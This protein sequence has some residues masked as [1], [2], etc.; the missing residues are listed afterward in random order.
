MSNRKS[1]GPKP[2]TGGAGNKKPQLSPEIQGKI[3]QQLR[4]FYDDMVSQGVPARFTELLDRLDKPKD[5]EPK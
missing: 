4:K 2:P 3:G 1:S 5:G